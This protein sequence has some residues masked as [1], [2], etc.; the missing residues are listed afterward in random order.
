MQHRVTTRQVERTMADRR[1]I[2]TQNTELLRYASS[3]QVQ[4]M[5]NKGDMAVLAKRRGNAAFQRNAEAML[6]ERSFVAERDLKRNLRTKEQNDS[7]ARALEEER[8]LSE[9]RERE[10]QR[11]CES[12]EELRELESML[13]VAYV[14][15]E[16]SVQQAERETLSQIEKS[17]EKAIE[18]QMEYD[19]QRAEVDMATKE[20]ARRAEAVASKQSI[21]EQ[22]LD[23]LKL[24]EEAAK[25]AEVDKAK[26]DAIMA[27][28]QAED[29]HEQEKRERYVAQARIMI[30]DSKLQRANEREDAARR[31]RDEDARIAQYGKRVEQREAGIKEKLAEK[32]KREEEMFLAVEAEIQRQRKEEEEFVR[33][34]DELWEEEML[35]AHREKA[36][37]KM[38]QKQKDRDEMIRCNQEQQRLKAQVLH[39]QKAKEDEYNAF[40]RAKFASEERREMEMEIFRR[41]QRDEYKQAIADQNALKV[42]MYQLELEKER[43]EAARI[44]DEEAFK[45]QIVEEAK[46]RLLQDHATS[47]QGFLPKGVARQVSRAG[48]GSR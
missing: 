33:L 36:R 38:L 26:V 31:D 13:K 30:E 9:R 16:R 37:A 48:L 46:R 4:A 25:E 8:R 14:N 11:I 45:K 18:T 35:E 20:I 32:K 23:R 29:R 44:A 1:R 42:Q 10:I 24:Y 12:S 3:N 47:L 40:L 17:R 7:L 34:R 15:K 5:A 2:E 41:K 27:Q 22:M 39:E 43:A 19:R 28:I 6:E 21:Q